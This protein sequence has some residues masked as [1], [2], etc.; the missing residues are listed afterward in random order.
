[1]RRIIGFGIGLLMLVACSSPK[2]KEQSSGDEI[3]Q[4]KNSEYVTEYY[5]SGIKKIEGKLVNGERHGKWIYYYDNGFIWSE[6][7]YWHGKR[8]G[9]SV[10]YYKNGQKKMT[11]QYLDDKKVGE[12]SIW[13][14][15]G[16]LAHKISL[17]EE[18]SKED[19]LRLNIP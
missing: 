8:K 9:Y 14:E 19:S 18:L 13:N 11:G 4:A 7:K 1:M 17:D 15:S 10:V 12:W 5:P 6:G 2:A 3:G 16:S